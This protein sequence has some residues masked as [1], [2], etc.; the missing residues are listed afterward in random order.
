MRVLRTGSYQ[1]LNSQH[2]FAHPVA[3]PRSGKNS[4]KSAMVQEFL[5]AQLSF[6]SEFFHQIIEAVGELGLRIRTGKR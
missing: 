1:L 3:R 4:L 5:D 2:V 6:D